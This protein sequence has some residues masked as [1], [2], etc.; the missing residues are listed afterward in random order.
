M[1]K[2]LLNQKTLFFILTICCFK[3][4]FVSAFQYTIPTTLEVENTYNLKAVIGA[5]VL[6]Q[7]KESDGKY[8]SYGIY[9]TDSS[10]IISLS[11]NEGKVYTVTTKKVNYYTQIMVLSTNDISRISKNKFGLSMRPKDCYRIRGKVKSPK[12]FVG[13]NYLIL[14]N[15]ES[16]ESEIIA[17]NQEGNY[18]GCATCGERYLVTPSL[19]GERYKTDTLKLHEE[20]C[21]GKRNPLLE[22]NVV[23]EEVPT[24]PV[25][26]VVEVSQKKYTK[27]DSMILKS[28]VFEGKS[29]KTDEKGK[30]ELN[31]LSKDLLEYRDLVIELRVHTDAR[32][33]ERYNW[34]LSRRRGTFIEE[35]LEEKGVDPIQFTVVPVG[36]AEILNDCANG[37]PCSK[38]EHAVNDRV[39]MRIL[40]D[41]DKD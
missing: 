16:N 31:L 21:Q 30:E 8:Y 25:V 19:N 38:K 29:Q 18:Y 39:E 5:Q 37:K 4:S 36:E 27:G 23:L 10:G 41:D 22:L 20:T 14:Q 7:Q 24:E 15:L 12:P 2:P 32:K 33:S 28:L 3:L 6:V 34:L 9:Y 35:F 13:Q 1:K 11:L 26:D 40:E 17:I